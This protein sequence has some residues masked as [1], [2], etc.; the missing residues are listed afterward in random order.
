MWKNTLFSSPTVQ[1]CELVMYSSINQELIRIL[2]KFT[3]SVSPFT[4]N[5]DFKNDIRIK[6]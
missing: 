6:L 3:G 4:E 2:K 5:F 1:R